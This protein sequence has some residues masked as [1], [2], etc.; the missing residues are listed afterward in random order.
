MTKYNRTQYCRDSNKKSVTRYTM[1]T[2]YYDSVTH[3]EFY[4]T[5]S[6]GYI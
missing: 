4:H 5:I 6:V 1:K 3:Q 2:V